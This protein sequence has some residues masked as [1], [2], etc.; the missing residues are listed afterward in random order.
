MYSIYYSPIYFKTTTI[1][2]SMNVL[3]KHGK[4]SRA[5]SKKYI[6]PDDF[7]H[8]PYLAFKC[9]TSEKVRD[10]HNPYAPSERNPN[11][12]SNSSFI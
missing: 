1:K 5:F 4:S 9:F 11:I 3:L 6:I 10:D 2:R 12:V 8:L 7:I